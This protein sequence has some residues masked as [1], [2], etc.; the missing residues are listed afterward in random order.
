MSVL[1]HRRFYKGNNIIKWL[2]I[3]RSGILHYLANSDEN[4][5]NINMKAGSEE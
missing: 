2:N 5:L 3:E 4:H 1:R